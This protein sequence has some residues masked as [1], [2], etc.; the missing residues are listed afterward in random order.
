MAKETRYFATIGG[1]LSKKDWESLVY[2]A[3]REEEPQ[4][5]SNGRARAAAYTQHEPRAGAEKK[6]AKWSFHARRERL[7]VW[8][9]PDAAQLLYGGRVFILHHTKKPTRVDIENCSCVH[10]VEESSFIFRIETLAN[11]KID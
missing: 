5:I 9:N 7:Y 8:R 4:T 11:K 3:G 6:L 10:N 1:F 2:R